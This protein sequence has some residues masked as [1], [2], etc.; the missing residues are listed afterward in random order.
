MALSY[1]VPRKLRTIGFPTPPRVD[2]LG[3]PTPR[4]PWTN[5]RIGRTDAAF[6]FTPVQSVAR[7]FHV[8]SPPVRGAFQL[9][10]TLLLRYRSRGVFRVGCLCHPYSGAISNAPYSLLRDSP[11]SDHY[12]TITLYGAAFQ[13][14]LCCGRSG[15]PGPHISMGSPPRI[16]LALFRFRSP[17]LTES[18]LF[19]FP[20]PTK[21]LQFGRLPFAKANVLAD[22]R[23]H[24]AISGSTAPCAYPE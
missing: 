10:L 4:T 9:S 16:R 8:F 21:M 18:R 12:G 19:S 2:R 20:L 1:H 3:L 17:L 14:T 22:R 13:R 15:V 6:A 24:S 5:F 11:S 23:S 7:W